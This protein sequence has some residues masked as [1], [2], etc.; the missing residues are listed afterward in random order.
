VIEKLERVKE[1]EPSHSI[2]AYQLQAG[3]R[4]IQVQSKYKA[5]F[6]TASRIWLTEIGES[7]DT[8]LDERRL[9]I[10]LAQLDRTNS[11]MA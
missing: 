2:C 4:A 9:R 5:P 7:V 8:V 10:Y 1:I 6:T 3:V 11:L